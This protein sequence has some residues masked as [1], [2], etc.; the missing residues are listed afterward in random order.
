A[1]LVAAL[2]DRRSISASLI[3]DGDAAPAQRLHLGLGE[4]ALSFLEDGRKFIR[5]K[6]GMEARRAGKHVIGNNPR[7][8][9]VFA[10]DAA[11][12]DCT[13]ADIADAACGIR[14]VVKAAI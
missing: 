12:V 11:S 3:N 14:T 2:L 9:G 13:R 6:A 10:D 4:Y 1:T 8:A 5:H 7:Q